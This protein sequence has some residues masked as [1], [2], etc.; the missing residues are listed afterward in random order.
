MRGLRQKEGFAGEGSGREGGGFYPFA[1]HEVDRITG[2]DVALR[3]PLASVKVT[4][5][6][7]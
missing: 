3:E 5:L 6:P 4:K 7:S 1:G 2:R